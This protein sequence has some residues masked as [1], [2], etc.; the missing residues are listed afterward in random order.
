M[1]YLDFIMEQ[2]VLC[3]NQPNTPLNRDNRAYWVAEWLFEL[4]A[5]KAADLERGDDYDSCMPASIQPYEDECN[6]W[7]FEIA[8]ERTSESLQR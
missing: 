4:K 8:Y 6:A 2:I 5:V 3:D 1:S 7:H